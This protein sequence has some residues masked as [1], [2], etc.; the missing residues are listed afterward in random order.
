MIIVSMP[1]NYETTFAALKHA[2]WHGFTPTDLVFPGF[3][4][5]SGSALYIGSKKKQPCGQDFLLKTF[6]RASVIFL[7]GVGLY[8][9]PFF[10]ITDGSLH[11]STFTN[12][13]I[14]GVLQRIAICYFLT[15]ILI[16]Y[17]SATRLVWL[18]AILL[19]SYW[20]LLYMLPHGNDPLAIRENAVLNMD[21][22][23]LGPNHLYQGEG[24]P[25]DPEGLLSTLP[26]IVN[27]IAGYLSLKF[28]GDRQYSL[29]SI[30]QV[31]L[32]GCT[33]LFLAYMWSYILPFNKKLWTSSFA[34]LTISLDLVILAALVY[35]LETRKMNL[36]SDFFAVFGKNPLLIYL[37]F[38]M[39]GTVLYLTPVK[40]SNAY[41]WT[42]DTFFSRIGGYA[43]SL[44]FAI[45]FMLIC[46]LVAK[47]LDR[48]KIYLRV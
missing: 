31:L 47:F 26:A 35:F 29:E 9:F 6:K 27:C 37:F 34:L 17:I 43:G 38:E 7:L 23:I 30:L 2:V 16:R 19:L 18:S 15:S 44:F 11:L 21:L 14:M 24:F 1:G 45:S 39:T 25:F 3:I 5:V 22:A 4:F 36:G 41:R 32:A 8:W 42:Y 46:W 33:L 48:R 40:N 12:I 13:R 10:R 28:L 20:S